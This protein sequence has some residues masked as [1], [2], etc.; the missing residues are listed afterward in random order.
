MS[1]IVHELGCEGFDPDRGYNEEAGVCKSIC[2]IHMKCEPLHE[3]DYRLCIEC[4]HVFRTEEELVE[5]DLEARK[6][7]SKK[8]DDRPTLT[9]NEIF[10]CPHCAHDF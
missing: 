3:G 1:E 4:G 8:D 9:G 2:H 5:A 10:S 6:F 7:W